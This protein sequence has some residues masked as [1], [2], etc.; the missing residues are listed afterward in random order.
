MGEAQAIGGG[1][2]G[3][4][5]VCLCMDISRGLMDAGT[6]HACTVHTVQR[7]HR[8]AGQAMPEPCGRHST[9]WFSTRF[10]LTTTMPGYHITCTCMDVHTLAAVAAAVVVAVTRWP[11][12]CFGGASVGGL[13]SRIPRASR[14]SGTGGDAQATRPPPQTLRSRLRE[15][16]DASSSALRHQQHA[17]CWWREQH[18]Q[19]C[20]D[21]ARHHLRDLAPLVIGPP[22]PRLLPNGDHITKVCTEYRP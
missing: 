13:S 16:R 18:V 5:D 9:C 7:R 15:I 17:A 2:Y 8:H 11:L 12:S 20:S 1:R 6:V 10:V 19:V 3:H 22:Q 4:W 21:P 14:P